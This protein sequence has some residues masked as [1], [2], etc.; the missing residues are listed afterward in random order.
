MPRPPKAERL[1]ILKE[2]LQG[3]FRKE[4][5]LH[6][7]LDAGEEDAEMRLRTLGKE[8]AAT[9]EDIDVL[10]GRPPPWAVV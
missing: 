10:E 8:I 4:R 9:I 6:E 3:L 5:V 1:R 2:C 7:A